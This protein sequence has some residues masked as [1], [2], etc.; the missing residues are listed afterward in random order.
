MKSSATIK[1]NLVSFIRR[2]VQEAGA[3]GAI[4]GLSGGIDSALT[5]YLAVKALGADKSCVC[6]FLKK[7][8]RQGRILMMRWR[9]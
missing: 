3:S 5:A 4:I 8:S 9:S 2:K 7:A 1:N 6:S